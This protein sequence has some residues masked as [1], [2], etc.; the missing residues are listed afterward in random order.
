LLHPFCDGSAGLHPINKIKATASM[1]K[2]KRKTTKRR[3]GKT[4]VLERELHPDAAGLDIAANEI[5]AAIPPDRP[6]E[7]VRSFTTFTK[8]LHELR[9]WLLENRITTV[10]MEST[11]SFWIPC[12]NILEAAGIE[13]FLVNARHV[14]GVPG[15]KTD[16]L[17]AQWLQQLHAAGLLRKSFRPA[18]DILALRSLLRHRAN[19]VA[20]TSRQIQLMQKALT[21]M[22][23]HL[24]HVLSD[25]D[26]LSGTAIIQAILE[27]E[28]DPAQLAALCHIRCRT[29]REKIIQ[30]LQ[31]DYK[32]EHLFILRQSQQS[33]QRLLEQIA[34]L[35]REIQTTLQAIPAEGQPAP[36]DFKPCKST[37]SHKTLEG[38]LIFKQALRLYGVDLATVDGVSV[39]A[40]STLMGELGT[41][42]QILKAFP[43]PQRFSS[44]LGLCP[45]NRISGGKILSSSTRRVVN[46]VAN[47]LRLCAQTLG[48]SKSKLGDYCRKMKSR[49]GK[50][51]GITATAHKLARIL[52]AMIQTQRPYDETLAFK[53][54]PQKEARRLK[55]FFTEAR[56]LGFSLVPIQQPTTC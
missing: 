39:S 21:E 2:S 18:N 25:L 38:D 13:V 50:A 26:G 46:K 49:L 28:R 4:P 30:A 44:W 56:R 29:P 12:Y 43:T 3:P 31:G 20:D 33:R 8:G 11:G 19:L 7:T 35:D 24:H 15:K 14:K 9:D 10:A 54:T 42:E 5:V 41:R 1:K 52:Y 17:D 23:L 51:E 32:S 45:D 48:H 37:S 34:E 27:G 36:A 16:V 53:L 22:N 47:V 6:D 55:H 40:L